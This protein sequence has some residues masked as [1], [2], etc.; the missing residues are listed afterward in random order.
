MIELRGVDKRFRIGPGPGRKARVVEAL[1]DLTLAIEPGIIVGLVGPN[2]AGKTTLFGL[3]L[4][5]LEATAGEVTIAGLD[6]R[7]Y[8]RRHGASYLPERFSVP[9]DW[10][11]RA[12]LAGLLRLDASNQDVDDVLAAYDLGAVA[13][14]AAH[15]LSRGTMQRLGM[16]QALATPRDFVILD[17]PAEGLDPLWRLKLRESIA[18]LRS[19]TRTVLIA[20][21]DL[22]EIERLA[23]RVVILEGGSIREVVDLRHS[24]TETREY[25]L[26]LAAPHDAVP[27]IFTNARASNATSFVVTVTDVADLNA[28]VAALID[29]G[30]SII[31]LAPL[32]GLEERVTR[33][34]RPESP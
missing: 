27:A 12:A 26:V 9:R 2:G 19:E 30:G 4:G 33:P 31:S 8:V 6:P 11:V 24:A 5:F 20:S 10:T 32:A 14:A 7:A 3:L 21:H 18:A 22:G 16:A 28:R 13:D 15:T 1:R 34:A 17:E 23:D 29:A 25:A